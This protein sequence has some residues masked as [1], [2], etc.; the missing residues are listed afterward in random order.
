V[1]GRS[2]PSLDERLPRALK[3]WLLPAMVPLIL[4]LLLAMEAGRVAPFLYTGF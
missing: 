1:T 2:A 4:V 3:L